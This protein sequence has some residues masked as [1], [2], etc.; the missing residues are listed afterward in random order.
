MSK[1]GYSLP[2][3]WGGYDHYDENGKKI[4]TSEPNWAGGFN[5]YDKDHKKVGYSTPNW[6]G[7]YTE[8]DNN[9]K[10][11]GETNP[12]FWGGFDHFD[13]N[14]K[15]QSTSEPFLLAGY[16]NNDPKR[17]TTGTSDPVT[18]PYQAQNGLHPQPGAVEDES[19]N[20]GCYIA[21]CVYGSYDCPQ[22]WTLRRFRD[23]TLKRS[24]PGRAFVRVYYALS[25]TLVRR[26]G[27]TDLFQRFWRGRLDRLVKRLNDKGVADLCYKDI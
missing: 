23:E 22:V 9:G 25:P 2:N 15:K 4:G 13:A 10:K 18:F 21:T 7:G 17:H 27:H 20:E 26:F 11:T 5:E 12:N 24:A 6:A 8:Y 3:F 1:K 14:G 19:G 16:N